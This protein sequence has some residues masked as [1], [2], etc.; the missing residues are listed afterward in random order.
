MGLG[1]SLFNEGLLAK[2]LVVAQNLP[3]NRCD[4]YGYWLG[5]SFP[6]MAAIAVGHAG[7]SVLFPI[8]L[9]HPLF[10]EAAP[11]PWVKG[12]LA[13]TI[14]VLFLF[15]GSSGFLHPS[16]KGV[17]G[18]PAQLVELFALMVTLFVLGG[19]FRGR[20]PGQALTWTRKPFLLGLSVIVPFWGG[21][22]L[23]ARKVPVVL[24]FLALAAVVMFYAWQL[25][26][27][28][29]LPTGGSMQ[30]L[31]QNTELLSF[32]PKRWRPPSVP[33]GR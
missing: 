28:V 32:M 24:F 14:A 33:T 6:W 10:S 31:R 1:H 8:I 9:T 30:S 11:V 25:R 16:E 18:T 4:H 3:I 20:P 5:L 13:V 29:S 15:L 12:W 27:R 19:I 17:T 22:F 23:A 26:R 2:T 7:T 21:V